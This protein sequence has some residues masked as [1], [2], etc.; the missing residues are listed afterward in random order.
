MYMILEQATHL[1]SGDELV[2]EDNHPDR[3]GLE[4]WSTADVV[5]TGPTLH[6]VVTAWPTWKYSRTNMDVTSWDHNIII[7]LSYRS[8]LV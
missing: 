7:R 4:V 8:M 1:F 2:A 5:A 3:C 6:N